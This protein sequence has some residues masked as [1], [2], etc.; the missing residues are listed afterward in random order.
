MKRCKK[1]GMI[2]CA[3]FLSL[4]LIWYTFTK[5]MDKYAM[6]NHRIKNSRSV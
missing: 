5:I 2:D 3:I 6:I 4:E 1:N